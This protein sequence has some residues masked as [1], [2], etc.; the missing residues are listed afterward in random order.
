MIEPLLPILLAQPR[1]RGDAAL[2]HLGDTRGAPPVVP[3]A[4]EEVRVL[5]ADDRV[6]RR[7]D[8]ALVVEGEELRN[9]CLTHA[10]RL[11]TCVVDTDFH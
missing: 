10:V 3:V 7:D 1:V 4:R 2:E 11:A 8:V 9:R 6:V 5:V